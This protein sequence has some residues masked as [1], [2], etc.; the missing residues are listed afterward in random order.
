MDGWMGEKRWRERREDEEISEWTDDD[1]MAIFCESMLFGM[2]CQWVFVLFWARGGR[3]EDTIICQPSQL[4]ESPLNNRSS[5]ITGWI[6]VVGFTSSNPLL[7]LLILLLL[8][9]LPVLL[10]LLLLPLLLLV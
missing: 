9:L 3:N 7:L 1:N 4:N 2:P 10:L 8:H 5:L 6:I